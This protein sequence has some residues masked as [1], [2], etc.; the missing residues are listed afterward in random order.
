VLLLSPRGDDPMPAAIAAAGIPLVVLG[1][2]QR[3]LLDFLVG[4][5]GLSGDADE[6]GQSVTPVQATTGHG[7][8][9]TAGA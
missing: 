9:T 2:A 5:L 6:A 1:E 7:A 8:C 3:R 4:A